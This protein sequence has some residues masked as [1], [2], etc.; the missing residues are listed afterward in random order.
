MQALDPLRDGV[1]DAGGVPIFWEQYGDGD[2]TVLFLPPWQIVHSRCWKMQLAYFAR[3]FRVLTFDGRG[4]GRSGRPDKGYDQDTC[5]ADALAV[6]DATKTARASLVCFSRSCWQGLILAA[7]HP[8]RVEHLVLTATGCDEAPRV[9]ARF[10]EVLDRYEGLDRFNA[11]YWR[12]HY[13]EF[14]RFFFAQVFP[15]PHST[16]GIDDGVA[17]GLETTPQILIESIDDWKCK[18]PL[19]DLLAR[20]KTPTLIVHGRDDRIRAPALSE[21]AHAG[22]AGSRLVIFEGSGHGLHMRDP[23]RYNVTVRDFLR[24]APPSRARWSRVRVRPRRALFVSING[25][26]AAMQSTG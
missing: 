19:A 20:V 2:R 10:H 21:R 6:L 3:F 26:A 7:E 14:L 5:A 8:E 1:V 15:E 18:T 12:A 11:H 24:P 25:I 17:W 4:N 13:E 16:K 22:I 9:I 23:V